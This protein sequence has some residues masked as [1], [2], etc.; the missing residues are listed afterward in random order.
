MPRKLYRSLVGRRRSSGDERIEIGVVAQG[1]RPELRAIIGACLMGW[2]FVEMELALILGQLLG[3]PNEAAIA[4]FTSVR[5]STTQRDMI[6]EA[7]MHTLDQDD[8]DLLKAILAVERATE[9]E[10]NALAH[11]HFGVSSLLPD[12]FVWQE[13]KDYMA[14]RTDVTLRAQ[15]GWDE[16]KHERLIGTL[17]VYTKSDLELIHK[18]IFELGNTLRLFLRYLQDSKRKN[19]TPAL[20]RRQLCDQ[21]NIA[22]ELDRARRERTLPALGGRAL[23]EP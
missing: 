4:V 21:P 18:D 1:N 3:S 7:G 15:K 10:R 2:P 19:G 20:R 12:D 5:R 14:H 23:P 9:L 13:T 17:F 6:Y 22:R 8:K 16:E 11:G